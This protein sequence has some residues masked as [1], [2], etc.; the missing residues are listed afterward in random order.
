MTSNE[1]FK[2]ADVMLLIALAALSVPV[3]IFMGACVIDF[4]Q[5]FKD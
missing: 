1:W 3:L 2:V 5:R 4:F